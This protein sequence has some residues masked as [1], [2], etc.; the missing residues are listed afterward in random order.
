MTRFD[1]FANTGFAQWHFSGMAFGSGAT[2]SATPVLHVNDQKLVLVPPGVVHSGLLGDHLEGALRSE[3]FT[4][5]NKFIWFHV[6]GKGGKVSLIIDGFQKIQDPIYGGLRFSTN[7]GETRV[8]RAMDVSMWLGHRAYIDL[9]DDGPGYLTIDAIA[10]GDKPPGDPMARTAS[11]IE[12]PSELLHELTSVKKEAEKALPRPSRLPALEDATP[13]PAHINIRGNPNSFGAAAPARFLEV[14]TGHPDAKASCGGRLDLAKQMLS[15]GRALLSRVMVNRLWK[16]HFGEGLVRTP[17]NFGK[18]GELPT[19]PELLDYLASEFIRG[20]W[21]IKHMHRLMLLSEAYQQANEAAADT[22]RMDPQNRLFSYQPIHRLEAECIRDAVLSVSG[23]LDSRLFGPS[24]APFLNAHMAGRGRPSASGPLD[25]AG[26]R[27]IYVNVRRNFL[28]PLLVAFDY[29]VP[30]T[31]M[32]RRMSSNVPAQALIMLNDPF[33]V[34]QAKVWADRALQGPPIKP[35]ERIAKLYLEA[36]GRP[37]TLQEI[38][39]AV[40]FLGSPSDS[41]PPS[42]LQERWA[43]LCHVLLNVKEFIFVP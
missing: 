24:V 13:W 9:A 10:V 35:A 25:G 40:A 23:R 21:S 33:V 6:G 28:S 5:T 43:D 3:S 42:D 32:G 30:F 8:W 34:G 18:L 17:D 11:P 19:Q 7:T 14:F 27:S 16:E 1:D 39:A 2:N 31:T 38:D 15:R 4:I 26:R 20:G 29:P 36:F 37:P 22:L 12:L 41:G